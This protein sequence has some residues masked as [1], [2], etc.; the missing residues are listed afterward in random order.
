VST[1]AT[2]PLALATATLGTPRPGPG[3][4]WQA[5]YREAVRWNVLRLETEGGTAQ[6]CGNRLAGGG[7]AIG[8]D[9][10]A[11]GPIYLTGM[12]QVETWLSPASSDRSWTDLAAAAQLRRA[13]QQQIWDLG[14]TNRS[15]R[16]AFQHT[17]VIAVS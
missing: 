17:G 16:G 15:H 2:S 9:E 13:S 5:R 6:R 7:Y 8:S 12:E 10:H 14:Y 4:A 11:A 1:E 3:P